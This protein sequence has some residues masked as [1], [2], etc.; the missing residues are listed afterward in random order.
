MRTFKIY[1]L[2]NFQIYNTVLLTIN[3]G[4]ELAA[5]TVPELGGWGGEQI[6]MQMN[7]VS[8]CEYLWSKSWWDLQGVHSS[9]AGHWLFWWW[10]LLGFS[11]EQVTGNHN[12][13][14]CVI[15]TGGPCFSSLS[16]AVSIHLSFASLGGMKPKQDLCAVTWKAMETLL[17]LA[18]GT[19]SS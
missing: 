10:N 17:F 7:G 1:S 2:S 15:T 8:R 9:C 5:H 11:A 13:S 12:Y 18:K 14:H 3:R 19:L 16:P 6:R 4:P